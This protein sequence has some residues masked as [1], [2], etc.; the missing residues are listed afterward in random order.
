MLRN[1]V[2][3]K[4]EIITTTARGSWM[5]N[6]GVIHNSEKQI[7]RPFKHKAWITCQLSF[8]ERR[9]VVMSP[10]RWT[11]LFF[12][13]EATAFSAGHRPCFECRRDHAIHFKKCWIEGNPEYG[14]DLKT[15]IGLID[16]IIHE[17]RI[18]LRGQKVTYQADIS[19]L[20][21][22]TFISIQNDH[23]VISGE[24]LFQWSPF[25]YRGTLLK[26]N[27]SQAEVLTPSSVVN[28]LA[29]AYK[30]SIHESASR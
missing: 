28:A 1:R 12:L 30:A 10:D 26:K 19:T 23:Y 18:N 9:R 17:Q 11:E 29:C 27:L 3:P 2:D 6:R 21:D 20:P 16:D 14:F 8:K 25:G 4:G 24:S 22:G 7:I 15:K 13:D 5:G